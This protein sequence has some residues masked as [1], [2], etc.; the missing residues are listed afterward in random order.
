MGGKENENIIPGAIDYFKR[1]GR[2]KR[3]CSQRLVWRKKGV[4]GGAKSK[5]KGNGRDISRKDIYVG[6]RG[7]RRKQI[8]VEALT[9]NISIKQQGRRRKK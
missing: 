3:G 9:K 1:Y 7:R 6:Q 2:R 5:H 8:V 4:V